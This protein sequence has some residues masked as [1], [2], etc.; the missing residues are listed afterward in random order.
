MFQSVFHI[1]VSEEERVEGNPNLQFELEYLIRPEDEELP[2]HVRVSRQSIGKRRPILIIQR[3]DGSEWQDC[4]LNELA[5]H[6]LLPSKVVGY[7]SGGNE[8]LSLPFLISRSGYAQ[9]V[10][11]KALSETTQDDSVQDTRLMLIDYGTNLEVL[12]ANL[13][14]S[15][16]TQRVALLENVKLKDIHSFR[17][18]I[19]LAHS[20]APKGRAASNRKGIQLTPELEEYLD[21]LK[22]CATCYTSDEKTET[23][24]FDYWINEE[25]KAA[26][27]SFWGT[28]LDL[29]SSF[30]KLAMLNDLAIPKKTRERFKKDS[31]DTRTRRFASRL[32][33]PQD[34]DKVFR[35][36][37]VNFVA[38]TG[39][40]VVDYV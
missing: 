32:P 10:G 6:R 19:Q 39:D 15:S 28:S 9:E 11:G 25:T 30:H 34:E 7:T 33:E 13:L 40:E 8:T 14:M 31:R 29:Y 23:Y 1:C 38:S 5:T 4:N 20:A 37:R 27:K 12:V 18:I 35:F 3:K 22:Y 17:C 2:V 26:F 21:N 16:K 36:E 24:I